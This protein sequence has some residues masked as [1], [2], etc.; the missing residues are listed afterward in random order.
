M[1]TST[2]IGLVVTSGSSTTLNTVTFTNL[3]GIQ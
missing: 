3:G 2:Y 1:A